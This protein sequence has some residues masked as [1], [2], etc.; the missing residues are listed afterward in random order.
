MGN[1]QS[2][3]EVLNAYISKAGSQRAAAEKLDISESFMCDIL[4]GRKPV[5]PTLAEKL[6][7]E[8]KLARIAK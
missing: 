1:P 6:G 5:P 7:F 4:K 3:T 2:F 8:W